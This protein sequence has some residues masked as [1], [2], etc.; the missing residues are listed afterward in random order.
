[1]KEIAIRKSI[2]NYQQRPLTQADID[3]INTYLSDDRHLT[4]P[5]GNLIRLKILVDPSLNQNEQ[6]GT[7]GFIKHAQ[8]YLMGACSNTPQAIFD[9]GYVFEGVIL[10]LTSIGIGTCWLGGTFDRQESMKYLALGDNEIIPAISPLG[11]AME[12]R[13]M[14][15]RLIRQ[16]IRADHRKA[17]DQLFFYETFGQALGS[18]GQAY[19]QAL[20]YVRLA[21]SAKNKQ[22]W[23]IVVSADE[24]KVHFYIASSLSNDKS[25]ACPPEYLDIG[26][27]YRHF[28]IGM[29]EQGIQGHLVV[30]DPGIAKPD[31][32]EYIASWV[33]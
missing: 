1:M 22:P 7:Y 14:K 25:F 12:N 27:A 18:H 5:H 13:H 3:L 2:R 29:I 28:V 26:I 33:C 30:E 11:Y 21:P 6:I 9:F 23:R 8:G 31:N 19:R 16:V 10:H 20:D 4:G 32:V 17:A 15:D 24:S